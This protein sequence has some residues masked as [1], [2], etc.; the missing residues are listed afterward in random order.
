MG[1]R[2]DTD[3]TLVPRRL[4]LAQPGDLV[5]ELLLLADPQRPETIS[6]G[7]MSLRFGKTPFREILHTNLP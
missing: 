6:A 3:L 5:H 2:S 7:K 4:Q 1:L